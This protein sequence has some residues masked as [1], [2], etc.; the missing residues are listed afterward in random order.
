[1]SSRCLC[2]TYCITCLCF[3]YCITFVAAGCVHLE[4]LECGMCRHPWPQVRARGRGRA[5]VAAGCVCQERGHIP[6]MDFLVSTPWAPSDS[7]PPVILWYGRSVSIAVTRLHYRAIASPRR[8]VSPSGFGRP[9]A[10]RPPRATVLAVRRLLVRTDPQRLRPLP[11]GAGGAPRR[12][13]LGPLAFAL[14]LA[15]LLPAAPLLLATR[16]RRRLQ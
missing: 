5:R 6:A 15:H 14:P 8:A 9:Q 2:F 3:T 10:P 1:M 12:F 13:A 16:R 7:L 11:T 4:H